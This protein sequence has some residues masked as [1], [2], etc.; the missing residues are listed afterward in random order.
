MA[1]FFLWIMLDYTSQRE[2]LSCELDGN[3]DDLFK[4]DLILT[5]D[6]SLN[7]NSTFIGQCEN[8]RNFTVSYEEKTLDEQP[9][10]LILLSCLINYKYCVLCFTIWVKNIKSQCLSEYPR[11]I[12]K[13]I[14]RTFSK[15]AILHLSYFSTLFI[16]LHLPKF[17]T[18]H[19]LQES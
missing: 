13:W 12:L 3:L 11:I 2:C 19:L 18:F 15:F 8:L 1:I 4:S 10:Q 17:T 5:N 6:S 14:I 9:L 16:Y 7:S